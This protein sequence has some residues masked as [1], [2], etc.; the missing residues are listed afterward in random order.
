MEQKENIDV[1]KKNDNHL[2]A[3][4]GEICDDLTLDDKINNILKSANPTAAKETVDTIKTVASFFWQNINL[5]TEAV[6]DTCDAL[7]NTEYKHRSAN[8]READLYNNCYLSNPA[9]LTQPLADRILQRDR[10]EWVNMLWQEEKELLIEHI[11]PWFKSADLFCWN[12]RS[13]YASA[14]IHS[15]LW[16]DKLLAIDLFNQKSEHKEIKLES[17]SSS[18]S[19][20]V[21]SARG[22]AVSLLKMMPDNSLDSIMINNVDYNIIQ[23]THMAEKLQQEVKRVLK[24]WWILFGRDSG[25]IW[26]DWNFL[27][28]NKEDDDFPMLKVFKNVK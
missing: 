3:L 25:L 28:L 9:T 8:D 4:A 12:D 6:A 2:S 17:N 22:D 19:I 14:E 10:N 21:Y 26:G 7:T 24:N 5:N 13:L 11:K 20:D 18:K 23:K 27:S 1:I 16:V 15:E